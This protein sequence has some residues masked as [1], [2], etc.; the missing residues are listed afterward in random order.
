[1]FPIQKA[2][3]ISEDFTVKKVIEFPV[4]SRGVNNQTLPGRNNLIIHAGII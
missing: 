3:Q 1:M 4:S 2:S